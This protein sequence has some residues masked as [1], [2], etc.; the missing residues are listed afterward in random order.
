MS[1]KVIEVY[2][3]RLEPFD[4]FEK[5]EAH[6]FTRMT[7]AWIPH[8]P[9]EVI[10]RKVSLREAKNYIN[11]RDIQYFISLVEKHSK[12]STEIEK[13]MEIYV[14]CDKILERLS[15][16]EPLKMEE[17]PKLFELVKF[18]TDT[19]F[20]KRVSEF[21]DRD[22]SGRRT[23]LNENAYEKYRRICK[24]L[25]SMYYGISAEVIKKPTSKI[26][27]MKNEIY[28]KMRA[29]LLHNF[30]RGLESISIDFLEGKIDYE[31]YIE[32]TRKLYRYVCDIW[33]R[34]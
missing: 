23:E 24:D 9:F 25:P 7:I 10:R 19:D 26:E 18:T 8:K 20:L 1:K 12:H 4:R 31:G 5:T 17:I 13:L 16:D 21:L 34:A 28:E 27:N 6:I 11:F 22:L 14:E 15:S 30:E 3:T 32:K 33:P 2:S 29:I